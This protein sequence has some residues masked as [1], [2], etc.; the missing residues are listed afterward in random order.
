MLG[1][2]LTWNGYK[3]TYRRFNNKQ[4]RTIKDKDK[5]RLMYLVNSYRVLM[6]R[7]RQGMIVY[8]PRP[9]DDDPS[10]LPLE[11]NLTAEFLVSCGAMPID[12]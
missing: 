11:L 7:A 6:T 12:K 10:R 4:W 2:D 5:R 3:W 1:E 9:A 8:V